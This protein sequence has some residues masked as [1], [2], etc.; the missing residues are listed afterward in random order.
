MRYALFLIALVFCCNSV[1][2]SDWK[3]IT[4]KDGVLKYRSFSSASVLSS[5][6]IDITP[7]LVFQGQWDGQFDPGSLTSS[8]RYS[9]DSL[10]TGFRFDKAKSYYIGYTYKFKDNCLDIEQKHLSM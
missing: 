5:R 3:T 8:G 1:F 9:L 6:S 4:F 7:T 10:Q 2:A